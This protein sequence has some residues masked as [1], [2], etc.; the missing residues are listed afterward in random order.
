MRAATRYRYLSIFLTLFLASLCFA[1]D[2]KKAEKQLHM[3]TAMSRDDIARSIISHTFA[4]AFKVDRF[5]LVEERKA[6]GLN[7]G[8]LFLVRELAASGVTMQQIVSQLRSHKNVLEIANDSHTNWQHI[9]ADAKKMNSRIEDNIYK[10]FMHPDKDKATD[11]LEHYQ[12]SA[13]LIRADAD[14][15]PEEIVKAQSQYMFWRNLAVQK[16]SGQ[17]DPSTSVAH[18]YTKQRE[19]VAA[20]H[21]KAYPGAPID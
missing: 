4:D 8:S 13:D 5:R 7:Y 12:P 21:G 20:T 1:D 14:V 17:A 18:D 6:M 15:A 19:A 16:S 11:L 2:Q 9:I 10:H 3:M